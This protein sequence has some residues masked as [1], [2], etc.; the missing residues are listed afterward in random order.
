MG[1]NAFQDY[2]AESH[3]VYKRQLKNIAPD[4]D[5]YEKDKMVLIEKARVGRSR[6]C[7][8]GDWRAD[9]HRQRRKL[10]FD[11]GDRSVG[12]RSATRRRPAHEEEEGEDGTGRPRCG[13]HIYQ[14]EEQ[15]VQ[16]ET[17]EVL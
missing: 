1:N 14:R 15:A 16:P 7:G 3:K 13:R 4:M 2:A 10:L 8:D 5:Q 9:R 12:G 6:H 11:G 17:V